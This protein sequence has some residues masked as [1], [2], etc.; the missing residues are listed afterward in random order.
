MSEA[1]PATVRYFVQRDSAR[2]PEC[3]RGV[4]VLSS[5]QGPGLTWSRHYR[6]EKRTELCPLGT[7]EY[8]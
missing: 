4:N 6:D 5:N 1:R 7:K 8:T 2:C 3:R